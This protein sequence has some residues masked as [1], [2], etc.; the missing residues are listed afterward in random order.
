MLSESIP[1]EDKPAEI[2]AEVEPLLGASPLPSKPPSA[3]TLA[4]IVG[5]TMGM[6]ALFAV[7]GLLRLPIEIGLRKTYF[8][9]AVIDVVVGCLVALF[10]RVQRGPRPQIGQLRALARG[11]Q[12]LGSDIEVA[13]A[14]VTGFAVR[15]Q[16]VILLT[17]VPVLVNE[18]REAT[19]LCQRPKQRAVLPPHWPL[20]I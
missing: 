6:G 11:F 8:T 5:V 3:S 10:L 4:G 12:L 7:F 1:S 14:C 17:F 15:S 16:S 13:M 9:V 19:L 20:P 18:V 2:E